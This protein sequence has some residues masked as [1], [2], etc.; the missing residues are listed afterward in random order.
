MHVYVTENDKNESE[1]TFELSFPKK[2]KVFPA[3]LS[4]T[5]IPLL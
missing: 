2:D 4:I 3:R 1:A 5:E